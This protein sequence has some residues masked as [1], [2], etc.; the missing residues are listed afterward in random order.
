M[1]Y[2]ALSP[3][4]HHRSNHIRMNGVFNNSMSPKSAISHAITINH[5]SNNNHQSHDVV[6]QP[7][8]RRKLSNS[9]SSI[10]G[11]P[12][13]FNNNNS[14][15]QKQSL[16]RTK[17]MHFTLIKFLQFLYLKKFSLSNATTNHSKKVP[18]L[19]LHQ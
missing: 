15:G 1:A 13:M 2:V 10:S 4:Q 19:L 11:K 7:I 17:G 5:R 16:P 12:Q 3:K 9:V 6:R 18:N 8:K 14:K